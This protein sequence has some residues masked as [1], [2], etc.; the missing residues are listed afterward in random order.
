MCLLPEE[1]ITKYGDYPM[2]FLPLVLAS[3]AKTN[4]H[5]LTVNQVNGAGAGAGAGATT[6]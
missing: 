1:L 2:V 6:R 5:N 3:L 4:N